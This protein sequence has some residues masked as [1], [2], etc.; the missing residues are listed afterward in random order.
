MDIARNELW[1]TGPI[2]ASSEAMSHAVVYEACAW[3]GAVVHVHHFGLWEDLIDKGPTTQASA[4]YGSPEMA[5]EIIRLLRESELPHL[6][7][8]AMAGH[9]EGIF[10]FGKDLQEASNLILSYLDKYNAK[11]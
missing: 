2:V 5:Y 7:I 11:K 8:F 10:T 3:V 6:K 1:C 4:T 9:K